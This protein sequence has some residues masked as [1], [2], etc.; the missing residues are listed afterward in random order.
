VLAQDATNVAGPT[1]FGRIPP[2]HCPGCN[3]PAWCSGLLHRVQAL[4]CSATLVAFDARPARRLAPDAR[5][6]QSR[7]SAPPR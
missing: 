3:R 6:T 4:S 1:G 2:D 5:I 7:V